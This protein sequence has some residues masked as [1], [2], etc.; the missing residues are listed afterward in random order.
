MSYAA[1]L[2]KKST[3]GALPAL[4]PVT[5]VK[6]A[7][8]STFHF[9]RDNHTTDSALRLRDRPLVERDTEI[10]KRFGKDIFQMTGQNDKRQN[11][12]TKKG[13]QRIDQARNDL[14]SLIMQGRQQNPE[15]WEGIKTTAEI[16][17]EARKKANI[18]KEHMEE[19]LIRNP[20]GASRLTGSL[21]GGFSGAMT[22]PLNIA[23]LAFGAG[24]SR[25]I[26]QAAMIEGGLNAAI[27]AATIPQIMKW[28]NEVGHKYGLREAA[29]DVALAGVGGAGL[30]TVIR[31]AV[32]AFRSI[33]DNV[34]SASHYV[35]DKLYQSP[36]T[37]EGVKDALGELTRVAHI[38]ESA[39]PATVKTDQDLADHREAAG[40]VAQDFE[41]YKAPQITGFHNMITPDGSMEIETKLR[42]VELRD[43]I[44]SEDARY[45]AQ[46][47]PR[48]RAGRIQSDVRIGEIAANLD[49][50]QLGKSRLSNTGAPIAGPDNLIESGNGRVSAIRQAYEKHPDS[51]KAY[52]E[53]LARQGYDVEDMDKP[54]L[55]AQRVTDL[56]PQDRQKF[57]VKSNED[58]IDRMSITERAMADASQISDEMF[59]LFD[60]GDV[61]LQRNNPFTKQFVDKVIAPSE[62]NAFMTAKGELS[63]DGARRLKSAMLAR[64]YDD[65][66]IIAA[67]MEDADTNIRGIGNVLV[68]LSGDW[69]KM[70]ADMNLGYIPPSLDI[71]EQLV[72]AVKIIRDSRS[73]GKPMSEVIGQPSMFVDF[74]VKTDEE[75]LLRGMYNGTLSR[76]L[77]AEK[78]NKF[79]SA[80]VDEANRKQAGGLI[81]DTSTTTDI[82]LNALKKVH[83]DEVISGM[84]INTKPM[85]RPEVFHPVNGWSY[86]RVLE[87]IN[88]RPLTIN[89]PDFNSPKRQFLRETIVDSLY[90][91]GASVKERVVEI[92][93]GPAG[94]GKSSVIAKKLRRDGFM[95]IDS[96]RA[97]VLLP[98]YEGGIGANAVHD[99]SKLI[100]ADVLDMATQ[101]GDNIVYPIVGSN[102]KKVDNAI[103]FF[104]ENG[105]TVNVRLVEVSPTESIRR[106]LLRFGET[107]RA[108]PLKVLKAVGRKPT[109]TFD[110]IIKRSDVND[111]THYDNNGPKTEPAKV[112][113]AKDR[114][115]GTGEFGPE[116]SGRYIGLGDNGPKKKAETGQDKPEAYEIGEFKPDDT[117]TAKRAELDRI[118]QDDP[119]FV[120]TMEDGTQKS[121]AE[122]MKDVQDDMDMLEAIRTCRL[123]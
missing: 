23:T 108:I 36:K 120:V 31:G 94:A 79:L 78:V 39:P 88:K 15:Q 44:T 56:S 10:K 57:T 26:L 69:S 41:E 75:L 123:S 104:I 20:S 49:P 24:A 7:A 121:M 82:L 54:V 119:D 122:I 68:E 96:D 35:L 16:T 84:G 113:K 8:I 90:G 85:E 76:P 67:I 103:D 55:I 70:R 102:K 115:E 111:W 5:G 106:A 117:I 12:L 112:I 89:M 51:A 93:T 13:K 14:D 37:P 63:A 72:N 18:S 100:A 2:E 92:I 1:L 30:S 91:Q 47:Q 97:K 101:A 52:K 71:T 34:G 80:Y 86:D 42:V 60:G 107:G 28:Q 74:T 40:K 29:T 6:D 73:I 99:E 64:A 116:R 33:K 62:R 48:D 46:L 110:E 77:S 95:E 59:D 3:I 53:F 81:E 22:D 50:E 11:P 4:G 66:N 87:E 9:I 21:V 98:E 83:S 61:T 19:I 118:V 45:T 109:S 58:A 27:E 105:Y 17:E 114:P 32:P 65:A 38:D 43:L 25:S